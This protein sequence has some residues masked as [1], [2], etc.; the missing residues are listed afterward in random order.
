MLAVS[1]RQ[2][3]AHA[4]IHMGKSIENRTWTPKYRGPLLIHVGKAMTKLDYEDF[5][6]FV[7]RYPLGKVPLREAL[8]RGG[9]I[10]RVD[11]VDTVS[12]SRSPWFNG[13]VGWKFRNS[14]ALPFLP[15]KGQLT[16]FR[17]DAE[18]E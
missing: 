4:I 18:E 5:V 7:R 1:V 15:W 2:P 12:T 10:G 6:D 13:P 8:P 16:L 14:Q 3:W 11:F 9:I 17:V